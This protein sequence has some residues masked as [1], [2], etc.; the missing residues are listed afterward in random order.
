MT[1]V[2]YRGGVMAADSLVTGSEIRRG[3]TRKIHR[4]E[5]GGLVGFAGDLGWHDAIILWMNNGADPDFRPKLPENYRLYGMWVKPTHEVLVF[6]QDLNLSFCESDF[7]A[8]GS[9]NEIAIGA[10]AHGASAF[11]AVE[12]ACQ[13]DVFSGLPV[14][15]EYLR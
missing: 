11:Q 6:S 12:I 1:T 4:L 5:D 8:Q 14:H 2:A 9:G 15:F 7:H 13:F 3:T 10:M